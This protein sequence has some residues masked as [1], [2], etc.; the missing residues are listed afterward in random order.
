MDE[1][2]IISTM[3]VIRMTVM[4]NFNKEEGEIVVIKEAED[5]DILSVTIVINLDTK[6]LIAGT[7][8]Q[9]TRKVA[10]LNVT[11]ATSLDIKLQ[12]AGIKKLMT[13]KMR[14]F[15]FIKARMKKLCCLLLMTTRMM[16]CGTL[17][18]VLAN[19]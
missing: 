14:Q 7:N 8:K 13:R 15:F 5:V 18:V 12:I 11:T 2:E 4:K 3:I 9:M 19:I 6:L 1:E 10:M 16:K 17:T